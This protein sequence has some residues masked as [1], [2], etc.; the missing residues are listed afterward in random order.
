MA[1]RALVTVIVAILIIMIVVH[2]RTIFEEEAKS[3]FVQ[4][5]TPTVFCMAIVG[6]SIR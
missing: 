2:K 6:R 5:T 1:C 4:D 3:R